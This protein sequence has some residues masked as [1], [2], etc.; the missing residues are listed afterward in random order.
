MIHLKSSKQWH[1][2][3]C[4]DTIIL[5]PDGWD[6]ANYKYSFEQE[7]VTFEEFQQRLSRSTIDLSQSNA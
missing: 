1:K 4:P 2:E 7:L 3:T 5:D 6:R